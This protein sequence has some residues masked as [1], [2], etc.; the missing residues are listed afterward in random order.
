MALTI[1]LETERGEQEDVI[2]DGRGLLYNAILRTRQPDAQPIR[3]LD[4]IDPYGDTVFNRLQMG[5]LHHELE[6]LKD[7]SD[8]ETNGLIIKVQN[9]AQTCIDGVHLC[10]KIYG[11]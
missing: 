11:D 1:A 2:F 4:F 7:I 6:I 10:I 8:D 3:L 5:R 9:L